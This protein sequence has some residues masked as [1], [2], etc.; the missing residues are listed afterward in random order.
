VRLFLGGNR[1]GK[2]EA[3][4]AEI[5][6]NA[7]HRRDWFAPTIQAPARI[8]VC[9]AD[10]QNAVSSVLFEKILKYLPK[11]YILGFEKAQGNVVHKINLVDG[12]FIKFMSYEQDVD[13]FEG[14]T[15]DVIWN[16]EPSPRDIWVAQKRGLVGRNGRA[17]FTL[18]PLKEPWIHEDLF[19][20][21]PNDENIE[22]FQASI[23]DNPHLLES[24]VQIHLKG[25]TEEEREARIEGKFAHLIG[26][27]Y[28]EFDHDIHISDKF[29]V[30]EDWNIV[31]VVDPHDRKP[32]AMIWAAIDPTGTF[33][34]MDEWP[35]EKYSSYNEPQTLDSMKEI[36]DDVEN[37][38]PGGR[39][40]VVYRV[41]DPNFGRR[42]SVLTGNSLEDDLAER[43]LYFDTG[44]NDRVDE[45]HHAVKQRLWHDPDQGIEPPPRS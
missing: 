45:G 7:T 17:L 25:L 36:I 40:Q 27:V 39:D 29:T 38:F 21:A 15:W 22:V 1:S 19:L 33:Y 2:T 34:I 35:R 13:K 20:E 18:T 31:H 12:G 3:G 8:M 32:W 44:V 37:K 24:E 14:G 16:D 10:F 43:G 23:F 6:A 11:S 41:L 5:V 28:P 42:R 26:R 9:G 30:Q 4:A